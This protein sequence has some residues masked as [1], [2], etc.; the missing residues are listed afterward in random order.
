MPHLGSVRSRT[1]THRGGHEDPA[2]VPKLLDRLAAAPPPTWLPWGWR[3]EGDFCGKT[4]PLRNLR[5]GGG[6]HH[7]WRWVTR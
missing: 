7:H 4:L 5:T 6:D 1:G 3:K 2:L